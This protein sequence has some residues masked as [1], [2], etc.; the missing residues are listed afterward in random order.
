MFKGAFA[1]AVVFVLAIVSS[2]SAC[3]I[4]VVHG[5]ITTDG[6]PLLWKNRDVPDLEQEVRYFDTKPYG[7]LALVYCGETDRAWAGIND[8]GFGIV[9]SNSYNLPDSVIYGVDDGVIM[10]LALKNCQTVDDFEVLISRTP[11]CN[12]YNFAVLDANGNCAIFEAGPHTI[13]RI[14]LSPRLPYVVRSNFSFS[15]DSTRRTGIHR[16]TRARY[17]IERGIANGNLNYKYIID[18]VASDLFAPDL[19]PYPLPFEGFYRDFPRGF[20]PVNETISR[21]ITRAGIVIRGSQSRD[22]V[23]DGSMIV[24]MGQPV[25]GV[26]VC[27]WV[28]TKAVPRAL[29]GYSPSSL[30]YQAELIRRTIE[31]YSEFPNRFDTYR[32]VSIQPALQ[33]LRLFAYETIDMLDDFPAQELRLQQDAVGNEIMSRYA[34]FLPLSTGKEGF[35]P[36]DPYVNCYPN[37]F[38][39]ALNIKIGLAKSDEADIIIL[40]M[41]GQIVQHLVAKTNSSVIWD[42]VSL[43]G[44]PAGSGLYIVRVKTGD[45]VKEEKVLFL[46]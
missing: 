35:T 4:A 39:S 11:P 14:D 2:L 33:A 15:G 36:K 46:K 10:W 45:W 8:A 43:R 19:D 23:S 7:F 32:F 30:C 41:E 44:E 21:F 18:T 38:N 31:P 34:S 22:R 24:V 26:P 37:P 16:Y 25:L 20:I 13:H 27:V 3:T 5:S 28:R 42:G 9:N 29:L 6:R 12:G 17:L 40:N 1:L